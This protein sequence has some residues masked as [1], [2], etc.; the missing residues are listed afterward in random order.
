MKYLNAVRRQAEYAYAHV[1]DPQGGYWDDWK[2]ASHA[3]DER[4]SLIENASVARL[5]WLLAPYPEADK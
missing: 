2:A 3:P 4:K 5:F 1:R